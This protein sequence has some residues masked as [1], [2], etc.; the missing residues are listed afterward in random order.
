MTY[1]GAD[2]SRE[3]SSSG[4]ARTGK[5]ARPLRRS[6]AFRS[7]IFICSSVRTGSCPALLAILRELHLGT[8]SWKARTAGYLTCQRQS[9][10]VTML[11]YSLRELGQFSYGFFFRSV[12]ADRLSRLGTSI[13]HLL[14]LATFT[15]SHLGDGLHDPWFEGSWRCGGPSDVKRRSAFLLKLD[16]YDGPGETPQDRV[17]TVTILAISAQGHALSALKWSVTWGPRL[18][19]YDKV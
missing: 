2:V 17:Q 7:M 8:S 16:I 12:G 3:L 19:T 13:L 11:G 9:G 1:E 4:I 5:G 14:R 18:I 15:G 6:S 10:N